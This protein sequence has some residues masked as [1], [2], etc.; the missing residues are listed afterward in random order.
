MIS[1]KRRKNAPKK[2]KE[3]VLAESSPMVG[4]DTVGDGASS[5]ASP[6]G[7][8]EIRA[9]KQGS[10]SNLKK[11]ICG[12]KNWWCFKFPKLLVYFGKCLLMEIKRQPNHRSY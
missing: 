7:V 4:D 1:P 2:N 9:V 5:F 8:E 6:N 3:N 11:K 10:P 12:G